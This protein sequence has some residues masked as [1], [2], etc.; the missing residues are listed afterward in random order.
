IAWLPM[1]Y[2]QLGWSAQDAGGLI[3]VMTIFQVIGAFGAPLLA[4]RQ[5]DRRPWLAAMLLA[6]LMGMTG[7]LLAPQSGTLL[8]VALIG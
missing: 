6:Q 5:P 8:W 7:L 1:F 3:G 4:R 2:R